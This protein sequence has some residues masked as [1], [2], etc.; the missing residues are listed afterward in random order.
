MFILSNLKLIADAKIIIPNIS[1]KDDFS[2]KSDGKEVY[3]K[4]VG[5]HGPDSAY[6]H[7]PSEKIICTGDNLVECFPQFPG[8]P[9]ATLDVLNRWESLD[10][11]K[12]IPGHGKIVGKE[13]ITKVRSYFEGLIAV[14]EN[15]TLEKLSLK[16][17]INHPNL[18]EYFG[19]HQTNW[20]K[21]LPNRRDEI[22]NTIRVWY[23]FIKRKFKNLQLA[24]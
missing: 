19:V 17:V 13:Y 5:G 21:G 23:R 15:L 4:V 6:I 18:P 24:P 9:D 2:I 16:E 14:L 11:I 8:D 20:M 1:I 3:F 7:V 12:I 22:E 10:I